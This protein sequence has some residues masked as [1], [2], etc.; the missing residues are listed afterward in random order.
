[1]YSSC[2]GSKGGGVEHG[3]IHW[4][5]AMWLRRRTGGKEVKQGCAQFVPVFM[6]VAVRA[7]DYSDGFL[8]SRGKE[9]VLLLLSYFPLTLCC[10]L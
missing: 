5:G 2:S 6:G 1:M 7:F 3:A 9:N 8:T 4:E 10:P